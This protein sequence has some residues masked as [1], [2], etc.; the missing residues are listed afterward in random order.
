MIVKMN[1]EEGVHKVNV[2]QQPFASPEKIHDVVTM[3]YRSLKAKFPET[4]KCMGLYLAN[5][6][7]EY[8]LF[9]PIKVSHFNQFM[10]GNLHDQCRLDLS[11]L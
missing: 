10:L 8:I 1:K 2:R 6:D 3:T 9:K 4:Q 7:T 11:N 5:R